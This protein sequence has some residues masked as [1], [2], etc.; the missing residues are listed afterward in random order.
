MGYRRIYGYRRIFSSG[1]LLCLDD[2]MKPF[3]G[4]VVIQKFI[5]NGHDFFELTWGAVNME[6][7]EMQVSIAVV[8]VPDVGLV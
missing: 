3:S 7:R 4:H 6:K 2:I 5:N 8:Y 1:E